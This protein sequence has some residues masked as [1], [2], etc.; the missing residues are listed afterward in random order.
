MRALGDPVELVL[1]RLLAAI[2][3]AVAA[4]AAHGA[5]VAITTR[6][7]TDGVEVVLADDTAGPSATVAREPDD[8]AFDVC[9]AIVE[10]LGGKLRIER[11]DARLWRIALV[12]PAESSMP[13][14]T[15]P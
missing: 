1:M 5:R 11:E 14:V 9:A 10:P 12:L 7:V 8:R 15:A 13:A 6:A 3:D 4:R 2:A